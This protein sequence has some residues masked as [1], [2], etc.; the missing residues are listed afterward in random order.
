[1]AYRISID[2]DSNDEWDNLFDTSQHVNDFDSDQGFSNEQD[3]NNDQNFSNGQ[4]FDNKK[5]SHSRQGFDS[6]QDSGNKQNSG[7]EWDSDSLN[8][9]IQDPENPP[10]AHQCKVFPLPELHHH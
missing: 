2:L 1:M 10:T 9:N 7:D 5:D 6:E 8:E 4:G 3:F